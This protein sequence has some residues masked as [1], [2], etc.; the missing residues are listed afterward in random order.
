MY[1]DKHPSDSIRGIHNC[2]RVLF[3]VAQVMWEQ[4][5]TFHERVV[6]LHPHV[7]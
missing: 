5:I 6:A 1:P 4:K 2:S 7:L 3:V